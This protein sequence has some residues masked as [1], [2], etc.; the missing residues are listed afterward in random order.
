MTLE[1]GWVEVKG[2]GPSLTHWQKNVAAPNVF[3]LV[4]RMK[5][6]AV[7]TYEWSIRGPERDGAMGAR[8]RVAGFAHTPEAAM[9]AADEE[10]IL[11]GLFGGET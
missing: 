10:A 5:G 11:R 4:R 3:L 2:S 9:L 8:I 6:T 7:K 1:P